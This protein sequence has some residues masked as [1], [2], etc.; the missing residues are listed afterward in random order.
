MV[1]SMYTV[2]SFDCKDTT[3]LRS[4]IFIDNSC[5]PHHISMLSPIIWPSYCAIY[6]NDVMMIAM[7][8]Q[9]TNLTI[10][11][12]TVYTDTDQRKQQSSASLAF[13]R[14]I[15][16]WS[17]NSPHKGPVTRKMFPFDD[18]IVNTRATYR[19]VSLIVLGHTF[20]TFEFHIH[21]R[22]DKNLL[23]TIRDVYFRNP[24]YHTAQILFK[25]D[26]ERFLWENISHPRL[27]R[28]NALGE[29]N[30]FV[31]CRLL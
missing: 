16:R 26:T 4:W 10:V 15:H 21:S 14:G 24:C 1:I 6:Y 22:L 20:L 27:S 30:Q 17:V 23:G 31:A 28:I 9:V 13:V 7:A 12:S 11:Y 5:T 8:S 3:S 2:R 25:F 19:L 18:V 29:K